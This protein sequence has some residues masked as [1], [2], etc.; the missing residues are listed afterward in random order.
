MAGDSIV[1]DIIEIEHTDDHTASSPTYDLVGKTTD[2]VEMSPNTE[3]ADE[4][5]HA[6]FQRDKTATS[7]AW[8]IAFA[9]DVV[10]GTAQLEALDLIDT[11]T[12]ELKGH[13]DSRETSNAN[14]AIQITVYDNEGDQAS[15]TVKWQVATDD[16]VLVVGSGSVQVEDYSTRDFTIHSRIRPIRIDAGGT[17]S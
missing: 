14:D 4:R 17:L 15:D 10:T 16:Y 3:V 1:G 7:E 8:E 9:A 6:S 12:Y 11:S 13:V 2:A 5:Q